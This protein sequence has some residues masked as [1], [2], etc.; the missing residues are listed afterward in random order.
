MTYGLVGVAIVILVETTT[1]S[2][3]RRRPEI[4]VALLASI[5]GMAYF[6]GMLYAVDA[7]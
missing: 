1:A 6:V 2:R 7:L 3:Q 5:L 4:G